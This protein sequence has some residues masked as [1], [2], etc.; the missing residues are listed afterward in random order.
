[1]PDT[2][3]SRWYSACGLIQTDNGPEIVVTGGFGE[4]TTEI[5]NFGTNEWRRGRD[6]PYDAQ[7]AVTVSYGDTLLVMGGDCYI[8]CDVNGQR[9][10]TILEYEPETEGWTLREER[11]PRGLEAFGAV[12]VSSDTVNCQ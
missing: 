1:M 12:F 6:L 8:N 4:I 11:L 2:T 10:S 5:Y 3:Y 9:L 7:D